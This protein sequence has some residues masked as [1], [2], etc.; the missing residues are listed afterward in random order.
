MT[1]LPGLFSLATLALIHFLSL[2]ESLNK[3]FFKKKFIAFAAGVSLSYVFIDL[4]PAID[5]GEAIFK[6][7][8]GTAIPYLNRHS[9]IIALL[10][11]LFYAWIGSKKNKGTHSW[12]ELSGYLFFNFVI[13]A[14]LSD[15]QNPELQPL[16]LFTIAIGLH[17]FI[18]DHLSKIHKKPK[19][20]FSLV[21]ML[22]FG[23]ILATLFKIPV[24]VQ[25]FGISF[26]AGG[27]LLNVI[28]FELP[29]KG[30]K[31][32]PFF[33]LGAMFYTLILLSIG[34]V[35]FLKL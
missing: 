8:L 10:G 34:E 19:M 3:M 23:Y 27:I 6:G 9:Y 32:F 1:F 18:R 33:F 35:K 20:M 7:H 25:A 13:G 21:G 2:S 26:A 12:L 5:K 24:V 15:S 4:L 14:A 29:D 16:F 28:G 17:Y 22:F 30:L 31:N 11:L